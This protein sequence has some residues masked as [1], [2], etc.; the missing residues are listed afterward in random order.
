MVFSKSVKLEFSWRS[1]REFSPAFECLIVTISQAGQHSDPTCWTAVSLIGFFWEA[2][3][4]Q[5]YQKIAT[6]VNARELKN[7]RVKAC[8]AHVSVEWMQN[9]ALWPKPN[10][11]VRKISLHLE[12]VL[13]WAV[14]VLWLPKYVD[15]LGS[16]PLRKSHLGMVHTSWSFNPW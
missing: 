4:A 14:L 12:M 13:I 16:P 2:T 9:V 1:P 11:T 6:D 5:C 15:T 10:S 7:T 8:F 3:L